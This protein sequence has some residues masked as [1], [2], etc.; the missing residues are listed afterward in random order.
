MNSFNHYAYGAVCEDIYSRIAGL[1]N[2]LP[3]WKKV[4]I[5]PHLN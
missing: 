1:R 3:G 2:L 5:K 4:M